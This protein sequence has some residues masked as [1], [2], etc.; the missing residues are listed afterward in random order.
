MDQT[1]QSRQVFLDFL[2]SRLN[3]A[4]L[5]YR[6]DQERDSRSGWWHANLQI[7]MVRR[8]VPIGISAL[9]SP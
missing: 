7:E 2:C 5:A 4:F 1:E 6:L 8:L 9:I 3:A